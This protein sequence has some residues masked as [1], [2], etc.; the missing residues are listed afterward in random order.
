MQ[1]GAYSLTEFTRPESKTIFITI[2]VCPLQLILWSGYALS[3]L[4]FSQAKMLVKLSYK[5]DFIRIRG[6]F[7]FKI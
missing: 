1:A 3:L 2:D 4:W 5:N 6:S 7:L